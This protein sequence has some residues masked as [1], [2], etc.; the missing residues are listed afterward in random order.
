MNQPMTSSVWRRIQSRLASSL[1]VAEDPAD[2]FGNSSFKAE[3]PSPPNQHLARHCCLDFTMGN[4]PSGTFGFISSVRFERSYEKLTPNRRLPTD[5]RLPFV[6]KRHAQSSPSL[7]F[8][9]R[10]GTKRKE[11]D[12]GE[13]IQSGVTVARVTQAELARNPDPRYE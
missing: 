10:D 11:E 6:T 3:I 7:E 4:A 9:P 13:S 2:S 8:K 1:K 12:E 5:V